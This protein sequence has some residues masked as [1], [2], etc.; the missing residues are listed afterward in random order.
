LQHL[1]YVLAAV[2]GLLFLVGG[3]LSWVGVEI[4]RNPFQPTSLIQFELDP[5]PLRLL[6]L[7]YQLQTHNNLQKL[8][9]GRDGVMR[10]DTNGIASDINVITE[11]FSIPVADTTSVKA[12]EALM[13]KIPLTYLRSIPETRLDSP[14]VVS[15]TPE[16]IAYLRSKER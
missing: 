11:L 5:E 8:V 13:M 1:G 9:I 16:G 15:V 7:L 14:Y 6:R 3:L 2:G 12:F 4:I 10:A